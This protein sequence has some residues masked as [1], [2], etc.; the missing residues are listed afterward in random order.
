[1]IDGD[2]VV[3]A[4]TWSHSLFRA[5][6]LN[7]LIMLNDVGCSRYTANVLT[8]GDNIGIIGF[9]G[10]SILEFCYAQPA[11]L[12]SQTNATSYTTDPNGGVIR[13]QMHKS[14]R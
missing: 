4:E 1:M 12:T 9:Y 2:D 10:R 14:S 7:V 8:N 6:R 11:D 5:T 3:V 13:M